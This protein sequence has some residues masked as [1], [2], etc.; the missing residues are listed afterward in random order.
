MMKT[1]TSDLGEH[2]AL[3]GFEELV[4]D[5]EPERR[6]HGA[7]ELTDA[8]EHDDHERVDDVALAEVGTDVADLRQRAAGEPGDARPRGR[9]PRCRPAPSARRRSAA[10]ARFCVTPRTKRPSRVRV[11]SSAIPARTAAANAMMTM[12]LH[13]S[14]MSGRIS[15]PPDINAGFSTCDVLRA[16]DR[17]HGLDQDEADAPRREQRLERPAVEEADHDALEHHA[18]PRRRRRTPPAPRTQVPV[19]GARQVRAE[20]VLHDV[21]R[22]R[23]DHDQLAVRHVDDAHQAVG[24]REPER[25]EQQDRAER[26][27]GEGEAEPLAPREPALDLARGSSAPRAGRPRRARRSCRPCSLEHR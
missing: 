20:Q 13:G 18:R 21:G 25:G 10:I 2:R 12:R 15:M 24:D 19:E 23:A 14:T 1:S 26:D 17:A 27:A 16:E 4:D 3:P 11:S 7:R 22:V 8:A 6:V 5:A 9:T